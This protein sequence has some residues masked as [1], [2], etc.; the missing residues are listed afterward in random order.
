MVNS[1]RAGVVRAEGLTVTSVAATDKVL[2]QQ[3]QTNGNY[4]PREVA[5]SNFISGGGT[6]LTGNSVVVTSSLGDFDTSTALLYTAGALTVG[7]TAIP[8]VITILP[9]TAANGSFK[10]TA[11]NNASNFASTLTNAAVGQATVYTLA[12]PGQSTANIILS[13]GNQTIAGNKT[14]TGTTQANTLNVGAS[15]TAGTLTI[16]PATAANGTLVISGTN[17]ASNFASILT[18]SAVGQATTYTLP[19]PGAATANIIL[20]AGTQTI[21]G[22]KTFTSNITGTTSNFIIGTAGNGLQ[23]KEGSNARMGTATL[24]TGTVTVSNTSVTA[25]TRIFISR[26]SINGS[27]ALGTLSVGTVAAS[28]SF[29][30]DSRKT[31]DATV[32]TNDISIVHWLLVEPAA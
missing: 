6:G 17:N 8:G 9:T 32:E 27:T 18:N 15:G 22:A 30:I 16:Y 1:M 14:L 26:Y 31:A 21:G 4:L 2:I 29:I 10:L 19:D 7:F 20:S 23:I 25:N 12:D 28:T 3:K 24:S 13:A 5:Y 11:T